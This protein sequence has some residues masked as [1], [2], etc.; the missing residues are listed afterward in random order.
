MTLVAAVLGGLLGGLAAA[1][2][3]DTDEL[4]RSYADFAAAERS[5]DCV[6]LQQ[7]TSSGFRDDLMDEIDQP[8]SC[9]TWRAQTVRRDGE[10]RWGARF[11][12]WGLL[13]VSENAVAGDDV[14]AG[15]VTYTLV[16]EDGRWRIIDR[17]NGSAAD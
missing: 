16:R 2:V 1:T 15:D 17:D 9:A 11:G 10:I 5:G 7:V 4:K 13:V 6:A 12:S 3:A 8:F 14:S